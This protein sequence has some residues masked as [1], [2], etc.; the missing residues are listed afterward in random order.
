MCIAVLWVFQ[1]FASRFMTVIKKWIS[2]CMSASTMCITVLRGPQICTSPIYESLKKCASR[3]MKVITTRI[4]FLWATQQCA[5]RFYEGLKHVHLLFMSHSKI[6]MAIY[7]GHKKTNI[8]CMSASKTCTGS[9]RT[10]L[11]FICHFCATGEK[12]CFFNSSCDVINVP[13]PYACGFGLHDDG[14]VV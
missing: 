11:G 5:S 14:R 6:C 8:L 10:K 2:F 7:E 1:K 3:F 4:S 13:L 9:C 12:K